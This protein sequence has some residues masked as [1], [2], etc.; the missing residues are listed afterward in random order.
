[1]RIRESR[2][3]T[4]LDEMFLLIQLSVFIASTIVYEKNRFEK[5]IA[6]GRLHRFLRHFGHGYTREMR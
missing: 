3:L 1:M 4:D 5:I 2:R 6:Q